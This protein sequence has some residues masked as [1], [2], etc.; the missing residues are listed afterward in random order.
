VSRERLL[1]LV[2]LP[3][4]LFLV[5]SG[6]ALALALTHPAKPGL[7]KTSGSVKLGDSYRGETIFSQTCASCHGAG[8]KGGGIG[9]TLAGAAIPLAV[10]KAQI[11]NGGGAMPAGL[12][13][14]QQEEDVLA[15]LATILKTK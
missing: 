2:V 7:P 14:G 12:V 4:A 3:T 11:E 5:V 9:P 8:G 13:K 15:Y 10:A 6:T 1:R